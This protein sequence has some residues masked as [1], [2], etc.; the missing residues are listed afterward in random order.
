[1]D[2]ARL[3]G[4]ALLLSSGAGVAASVIAP[5]RWGRVG[6][7]CV[8]GGLSVLAGRDAAMIASGSLQRLRMVPAMLLVAEPAC[9]SAGIVL[10]TRAWLGRG[11][12]G[13]N[14]PVRPATLMAVTS[15]TIHAIRQ[16]LLISHCS[17]SGHPF[18][19]RR[20][21]TVL[22]QQVRRTLRDRDS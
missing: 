5:R 10:G 20:K 17:G 9:A 4:Y 8:V 12:L 19:L 15:F 7:V 2:T 13:G 16:A 11:N 3:G 21:P 6:A 22:T 1:M 18:W 14:P